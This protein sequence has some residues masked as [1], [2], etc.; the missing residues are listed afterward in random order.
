MEP[1]LRAVLEKLKETGYKIQDHGTI[2]L[3]INL[4]AYADDLV[5]LS[6][7]DD[8]LQLLIDTCVQAAEWCG[9]FFK[10]PKCASIHLDHRTHNAQQVPQTCFIIEENEIIALREGEHYPHL[11]V[12]TRYRNRQTPEDTVSEIMNK[13]LQLDS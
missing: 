4:L 8:A 9:L 7:D 5:L 2:G 1:I 3:L 10:P 6:K 11:G 12:P 13:F